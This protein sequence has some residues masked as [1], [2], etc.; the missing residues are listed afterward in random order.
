MER[1]FCRG[2]IQLFNAVS[3]AQQARKDKLA[4]GAKE[5]VCLKLNT[6]LKIYKTNKLV[7]KL[8]ID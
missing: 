8:K 2:V 3:K 7:F 1:L 5:K 6:L 4:A